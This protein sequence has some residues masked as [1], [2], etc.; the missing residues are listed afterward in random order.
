MKRT[1]FLRIRDDEDLS[2]L[3]EDVII[4]NGQALEMSNIYTNILGGTMDAFASIISN[5]LNLVIQRLTLITIILMVP[6]LIASYFGMNVPNGLEDSQGA[7]FLIIVGS[8]VVA[9]FLALFF[10]RKR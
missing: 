6:T 8:L 2:D 10:F 3:M 7:L 5:N 4:D 1:D 9:L